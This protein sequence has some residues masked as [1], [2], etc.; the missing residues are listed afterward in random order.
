MFVKNEKIG[1][2]FIFLDCMDF[3]V[4]LVLTKEQAAEPVVSG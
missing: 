4:K 2:V 3:F 1:S